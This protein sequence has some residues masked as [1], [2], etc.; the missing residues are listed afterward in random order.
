VREKWNIE[1]KKKEEESNGVKVR[2]TEKAKRE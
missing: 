2:E 1:S